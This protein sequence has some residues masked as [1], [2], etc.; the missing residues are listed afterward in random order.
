[1]HILV[2]GATGFIGSA[3][4]R[5][6]AADGYRV[7]ASQVRLEANADWRAALQGIDVVIHTAARMHVVHDHSRDPLTEFRK[8]NVEGTLC[9][10]RQAAEAGVKRLIFLSSIKVNGEVTAPNKPF[11]AEDVPVPEDAYAL[12]KLEAEKGLEEIAQ[13]HGMELVIIRP[14][15]VY[16]PAV[17]GNMALLMKLVALRLPLPLGS[18]HNARSL[19]ALDNLVDLLCCCLTHPAAANQVFLVSDGEDVSTPELLQRMATAMGKNAMLL[20]CPTS[21]LRLIGVVL[22]KEHIVQRLCGSLTLDISKT[23]QLLGWKPRISMQ[24]ALKKA[25][26]GC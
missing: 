23:H 1:M 20:P 21:L 19:V 7:T 6:M 25:V 10:A 24:E 5:R 15:L 4:M 13:N 26:S 22:G 12:S 16:G 3:V 17:K 9:F 18:I 8:V 11:T 14:P 2:T